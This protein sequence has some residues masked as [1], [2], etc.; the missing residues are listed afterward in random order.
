MLYR[1]YYFT[2][3]LVF[4]LKKMPLFADCDPKC[5]K[6][7]LDARY[8]VLGQATFSITCRQSQLI[9]ALFTFFSSVQLTRRTNWMAMNMPTSSA[10]LRGAGMLFLGVL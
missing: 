2:F 8:S 9:N 10:I 3:W 7:P 5:T 6:D 4:F 1:A